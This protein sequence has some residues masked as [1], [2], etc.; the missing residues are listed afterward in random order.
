[1]I[2]LKRIFFPSIFTLFFLFSFLLFPVPTAYAEGLSLGIEPPI[3]QI[4]ATPAASIEAPITIAN[5]GDD[6]VTLRI[7]LRSFTAAKSEDG[8]VEFLPEGNRD[9]PDPLLFQKV[10]VRDSDRVIQRIT[11]APK[12]QKTLILHI[13]IP[14]EQPRADYYFSVVFV[15]D[16]QQFTEQSASTATGGI[17]T[18]VLLSVGP[19]GK[20]QGFLEEFSVPFFFDR[21]PVPFMVRITNTGER[22]IAPQGQILI[23]NMF[24]QT[25]GKVELLPVNVLANTTRAFPDALQASVAT[26]SARG[27]HTRINLQNAPTPVVLWPEEFLLGYY[28]ATLT[29]AVS[30][31]GPV[32]TKAVHFVAIPI[33]LILGIL[34]TVAILLLMYSRV[35]KKLRSIE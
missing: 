20:P 1:M 8:T 21:G 31:D 12:Q 27:A 26:S 23:T 5:E 24:G 17:A 13:G 34:V 18:N 29:V 28:T 11:L 16:T 3:L 19:K 10:Q 2:F 32:L 35:K 33:H 25:I 4:E 6:T 7:L 15:A 22:V 14:K 30:D 9:D